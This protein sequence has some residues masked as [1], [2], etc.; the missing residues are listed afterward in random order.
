MRQTPHHHYDQLTDWERQFVDKVFD[1]KNL[2]AMA[3]AMGI[4]VAG[5]DRME[6]AV[7][8]LARCVIE[9]RRD[10]REPGLTKKGNN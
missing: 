2:Y 1:G 6:R 5:D 10:W 7:D 9:S 4:P 8:A 3:N